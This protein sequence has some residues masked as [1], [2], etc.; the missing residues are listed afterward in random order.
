MPAGSNLML[1]WLGPG[2]NQ[3]FLP[4]DAAHDNPQGVSIDSIVTFLNANEVKANV[5]TLTDAIPKGELTPGVPYLGPCAH[6][7]EDT[8]IAA[9][10]A[11]R[12]D[13]QSEHGAFANDI[14][15]CWNT[16]GTDRDMDGAFDSYELNECLA[17]RL[18]ARS[19]DAIFGRIGSKPPLK[20][21]RV[22]ETSKS[23]LPTSKSSVNNKSTRRVLG[24][25]SLATGVGL[26][27]GSIV[28]YDSAHERVDTLSDPS[29][30]SNEGLFNHARD[31]YGE[32]RTTSYVLRGAAVPFI[33]GG[34]LLIAF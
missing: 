8:P 9:I 23:V 5:L 34:G 24:G 18:E 31:R 30:F 21:A 4:Y 28:A 29:S 25:V 17:A 1:V 16:P 33:V 15:A 22:G 27:V 20:L 2:V 14:L 3:Q 32:A 13:Y 19:S 6:R 12:Y 26:A 11:T 10:S 7:F